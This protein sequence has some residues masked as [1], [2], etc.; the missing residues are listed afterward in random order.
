MLSHSAYL[1]ASEI[2]SSTKTRRAII[3]ADKIEVRQYYFDQRPTLKA[4][5]AVRLL[6]SYEE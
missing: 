6:Q 4:L 3:N 1:A 2:S 5:Q